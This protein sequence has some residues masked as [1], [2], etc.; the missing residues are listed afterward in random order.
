MTYAID[1]H[2]TVSDLEASGFER[3]QAER[4]VAAIVSASAPQLT[5][6]DLTAALADVV[7]TPDLERF[8][9]KADLERFA[10]KADL[11]RFATKADLERF[12]TKA[13][14]ERFATK[15]ELQH[16]ATKA[17][18]Q[19]FATKH[20]LERYATKADLEAAIQKLTSKLLAMQATF[21]VSMVLILLGGL[22]LML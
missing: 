19:R 16:F 3:L 1:T 15:D 17:D 12:A 10:T 18:L 11:E 5:Q 9:T 7:R 21:F 20:D 8:A 4:I 13:D 2:A 14:L 6:S 22:R